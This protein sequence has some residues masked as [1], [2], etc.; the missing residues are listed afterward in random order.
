MR[1]CTFVF[2]IC[3]LISCGCEP[4]HK[5]GR[6]ADPKHEPLVGKTPE[7]MAFLNARKTACESAAQLLIRKGIDGHLQYKTVARRR[8]WLY[9]GS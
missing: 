1:L 8:R 3:C 9:P 5:S 2:S 7:I 6:E 4:S